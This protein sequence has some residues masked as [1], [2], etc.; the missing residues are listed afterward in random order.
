MLIT[1][2]Y[3]LMYLF[4]LWGGTKSLGT[5]ANSGL[6]YKPQMIDESDC[7][8]IGGMKVDRGN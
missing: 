6:L 3:D 4:L 7:G 2:Q 1:I 5:A 8:A